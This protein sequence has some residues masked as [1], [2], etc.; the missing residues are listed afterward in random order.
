MPLSHNNYK[1]HK[2]TKIFE[3]L[4]N[5]YVQLWGK[6]MKVAM[7]MN[8]VERNRR[9]GRP[10]KKRLNRIVNALKITSLNKGEVGDRAQRCKTMVAKQLREKVKKK[11]TKEVYPALTPHHPSNKK[12][13]K[14][15]L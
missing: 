2:Y 9:K 7:E 11:K 3:I 14:G 8:N 6:A 10:K 5:V 4:P 15:C 13:E 12:N 1:S